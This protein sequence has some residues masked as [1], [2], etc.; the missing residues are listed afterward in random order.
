MDQRKKL[1]YAKL[2]FTKIHQLYN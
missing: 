2:E 1:D